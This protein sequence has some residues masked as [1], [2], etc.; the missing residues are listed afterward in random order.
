MQNHIDTE[1]VLYMQSNQGGRG[2][3]KRRALLLASRRQ[4]ALRCVR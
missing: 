3:K 4:A 1:H 2:G